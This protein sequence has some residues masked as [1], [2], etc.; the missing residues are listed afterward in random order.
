[1]TTELSFQKKLG[2]HIVSKYNIFLNSNTLPND[3]LNHSVSAD[4]KSY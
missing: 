4:L 1:M 3:P 2:I